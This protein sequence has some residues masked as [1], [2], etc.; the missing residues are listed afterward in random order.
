MKPSSE[1]LDVLLRGTAPVISPEEL[2]RKLS[3]SRPLRVKLGVD[4][5]APDLHLGHTVA[6]SKLRQFQDFGHVAV[7]IIGDFTSMIGDPTGRSATRPPLSRDEILANAKTYQEQAFKVL[8][9]E[10]LEMVFNGDWFAKMTFAEIIQLSSAVSISQMMQRRDF[11]ERTQAGSD[12]RHHETFYPIMQGWDSVMVR[13]D[14]ELG[15]T[16]Q[17]FN[18]MVGRDL[19][20]DHGQEPQVAMLLPILEGTDG[21]QKM[22]KSLGNYIGVSESASEIFGKTMSISDELMWKWFPLLL[23]KSEADLVALKSG[24]PME[25]KKTLA[26]T[27]AA[28]FEGCEAAKKARHDFERKFSARDAASADLPELSPKDFRAQGGVLSALDLVMA[29][30][31]A[32]SKGEARRLIQQGGV[33]LAE[34][35]L[36]D[37]AAPVTPKAGDVFKVGKKHFFRI[38]AG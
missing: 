14:V 31:V 38:G 18:I 22:S 24:H 19:Q 13:A 21:A 20:K 16:D 27:L 26:E 5:T 6:L 10:R 9:R 37:P 35:R 3:A 12:I 28:R 23:G 4:P 34:T 33:E 1:Q 25:A 32:A 11:R 7:L 29:T 36:G 15:G 2:R 30:G 8:D 17:L